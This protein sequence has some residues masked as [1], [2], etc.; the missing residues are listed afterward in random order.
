MR[1]A[2]DEAADTAASIISGSIPMLRLPPSRGP[3]PRHPKTIDSQIVAYYYAALTNLLG[4]ACYL[5]IGQEESNGVLQ[6]IIEASY[7]DFQILD[8]WL[9]EYDPS[10]IRA[11]PNSQLYQEVRET[12]RQRIMDW[13]MLSKRAK[14]EHSS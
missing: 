3:Q 9:E 10:E 5:P 13:A 11:S 8:N 14:A 1:E 4:Q 6:V 12:W 2:R 7:S